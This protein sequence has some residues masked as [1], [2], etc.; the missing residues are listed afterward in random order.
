MKKVT[1]V[2]GLVAAASMSFP[3][4]AADLDG[5]DVENMT[6]ADIKEYC[7]MFRGLVDDIVEQLPMKIDTSTTMVGANVLY[8]SGLCQYNTSYVINEA[9]LFDMLQGMISEAGGEEVPMDFVQQFY[10]VG[11]GYQLM[12]DGIREATLSDPDMA[13]VAAF[14][15]M[16]IK[17]RY[18]V[19]GRHMKSFT[20]T[21]A[22]AAE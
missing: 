4:L 17:A 9:K 21:I 12:Q 2:L 1:G 18:D 6:A 5:F 20:I 7:V 19:M 3:V 16:A 8:V 15:F 11:E 13:Q 10:S 14:P 22:E